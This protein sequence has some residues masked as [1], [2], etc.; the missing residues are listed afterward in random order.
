M[1]STVFYLVPYRKPTAL[2]RT[3][4]I[5]IC[6]TILFTAVYISI[7][8][9]F[10][11]SKNRPIAKASS[12]KPDVPD[13][14]PPDLKL[15]PPEIMAFRKK[16]DT[17]RCN[18]D[19]R[20]NW[21]Y[22]ENGKYR[23]SR[24]ATESQ[25][26]VRCSYVPILRGIDDYTVGLGSKTGFI[27]GDPLK[28]D[29][30]EVHCTSPTTGENYTNL[31]SGIAYN[32]SLFARANSTPGARNAMGFDVLM[33][34]YDSVSRLSWMR[35][36]PKTYQYFTKDLKGTVLEGYNIVGD[37]TTHALFP[38]LTGLTEEELPESRRGKPGAVSVE[39]FP[40]VWKDYKKHGFITQWAED[41]PN[42]GAFHYRLLGFN[43]TPTDHY[44]RVFYLRKNE[45]SKMFQRFC[46]GS[47]SSHQNQLNWIKEAFLMYRD[48]PKFIFSFHGE[49][50]HYRHDTKIQ[51]ADEELAE[52]L[53]NLKK[54]GHLDTT[55]LILMADHGARFGILRE[56]FQGKLE[57][58]LPF[59]SFRFPM[60]FRKLYPEAYRNFLINAK[61]LTCPFDIHATF[62]DMLNY[63]KHSE[64]EKGKLKRGIS[65]FKEIPLQRT[66]ADAGIEP[67]WCA[68]QKW[69][70]ITISHSDVTKATSEVLSTI[71]KMTIEK[72]DECERLRVERVISAI[73]MSPDNAKVLTYLMASDYDGRVP[74][75][76][77]N[78]TVF[79]IEN[80]TFYQVT[81]ETHP[82][83]GRFEATVY[84]M[85][86]GKTFKC[87]DSSISRINKYGKQPH[88]VMRA[89]PHLRPYCY[90]KKQK[91]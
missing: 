84:Q 73:K 14:V 75:Y 26:T 7:N 69:E 67:H 91:N 82:G 4:S 85:P 38:M 18:R 50:S 22:V 54:D 1:K 21:V 20:P 62:M 2:S 6:V 80:G 64:T 37:G 72:K 63:N 83:L 47:V 36:L 88:C 40:F 32:A 49:Y 5:Y 48:N 3:F 16:V 59:F 89:F 53:K 90:C 31:V 30:S 71:N 35:S 87:S 51:N 27:D 81:I 24:E 52:F 9:Q 33:I 44:M 13:C 23:I 55:V 57:E 74:K 45:V 86:D 77:I 41:E 19:A 11:E 70:N 79:S 65:L 29:F 60:K 25:G 78:E 34:G 76:S 61:R 66:C 10:D 43:E 17:V 39:G 42:L 58:R 46:L 56:T 68:C 8:W 15:F 12:N 28:F